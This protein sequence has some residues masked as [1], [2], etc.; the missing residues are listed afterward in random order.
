MKTNLASYLQ[1]GNRFYGVEQTQLDNAYKFYGIALIKKQ[2][3][4]ELGTCLESNTLDD[5]KAQ[6]PKSKPIILVINT[7]SVLTKK[8]ASTS[9]NLSKLVHL[10]FPNIT[11][12]EFYYESISQGENHFVSICRKSYVDEILESYA[13][14]HIPVINFTLGNLIGSNVCSF[15]DAEVVHTS[16]ASLSI[17]NKLI[18]N[19]TSR[20]NRTELMFN[21]NGL[22]IESKYILSCGAALHTILN[23]D[24]IQSGFTNTKKELNIRFKQKRFA[25]QFLKIG[26][27]SL[28]IVLLINALFFNHYY[29]A[30][31]SLRQTSQVLELSKTKMME[32]NEEIQKNEK[33]VTDILKNS[34]SKSSFYINDIINRLPETVILKELNYQPLLKKIKEGNDIEHQ[35]NTIL[36]SG[37][38]NES[39]WFS[40]WISQLEAIS[41]IT[42]VDILN[43]EDIA[44]SSSSFTIKIHMKDDSED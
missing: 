1:F 13:A 40:R 3:Q 6:L 34:S 24:T 16:N 17:D 42:S 11:V 23:Y 20:E 2:N 29:N 15:I 19:I 4:L 5:L 30:V 12:D 18:S 39:V 25:S 8:V 31:N 44:K 33:I 28:F 36:I 41:W 35:K 26:L 27:G 37:Q 14:K 22:D 7:N 21:I 9:N 43:F 38:I 10:A 32:L